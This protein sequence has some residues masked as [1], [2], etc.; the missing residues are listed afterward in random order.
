MKQGSNDIVFQKMITINQK[1]DRNH[2]AMQNITP[3]LQNW[4]YEHDDKPTL[5][6][7]SK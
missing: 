4:R 2:N 3:N 5:Y 6:R 7:D 1:K